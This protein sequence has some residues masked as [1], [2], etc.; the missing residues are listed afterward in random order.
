MTR[1]H[2]DKECVCNTRGDKLARGHGDRGRG[3]EAG[4]LCEG[5]RGQGDTVTRGRDSEAEIQGRGEAGVQ[6]ADPKIQGGVG[7]SGI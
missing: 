5:T 6:N 7:L 4:I 2:G 1:G 3:R